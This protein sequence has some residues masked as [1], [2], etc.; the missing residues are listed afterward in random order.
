MPLFLDPDHYVNVPLESTYAGSYRGMPAFWR[1]VL[2]EKP[3]MSDDG[4]AESQ[5]K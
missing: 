2:Q 1:E 3:T 5:Q 4:S